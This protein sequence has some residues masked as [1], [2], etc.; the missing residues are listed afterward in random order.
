MK[1]SVSYNGLSVPLEVLG[2]VGKHAFAPSLAAVAVA[3]ALGGSL[4][5]ATESLR[6]Y[7]TPPG[8]MRLIRGIKNTALIDDTYNSSPAA[9]EAALETLSHIHANGRRIAVLGDMLELGRHSV[10]EHKKMGAVAAQSADLLVTIGFRAVGMAQGALDAGM[11][12]KNILQYE[13][14]L[15]AGKELKN[16]VDNG[17]VVLLKGS[18]SIR[19]ERVVEELMFE[20]ERAS[21]LLVRQEKEWKKR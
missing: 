11:P 19:V 7:V 21:Q 10:T 9:V 12:E 17:D 6:A 18:Q 16:I 2:S 14:S 8:R 3:M 5:E 1:G 20:P 15:V 4:E 13:D